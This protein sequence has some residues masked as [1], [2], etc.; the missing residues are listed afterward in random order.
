MQPPRIGDRQPQELERH[1][2]LVGIVVCDHRVHADRVAWL[3]AKARERPRRQLGHTLGVVQ[4]V[5]RVDAYEL[6]PAV[7]T[8]MLLQPGDRLLVDVRAHVQ[9]DWQPHGDCA[10]E[11]D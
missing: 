10:V 4:H 2:S 7:V 11:A 1:A 5:A 9:A 6:K 3:D 8:E